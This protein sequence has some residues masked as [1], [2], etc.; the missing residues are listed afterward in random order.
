MK[1]KR[2]QRPLELKAVNEDGTFEGYGSVFGTIDSYREVVMPGAFAQTLAEHAEKGSMPALLWQHRSDSPIGVWT[3]MEEDDH[4][5]KMSGSLALGTQQGRE[6]HE[7]LK[8]GAV[9]GLSIGFTLYEGGEQ[10]NTEN[11]VVE[12][13]AINLW[14]TSIVTF[15]ANADAQITEVRAA[16]DA[17]TYPTEREFEKHLRDVGFSK[18]DALAIVSGGYQQLRRDSVPVEADVAAALML[19]KNIANMKP[20]TTS[21]EGQ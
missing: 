11:S 13:T 10:Y 18:S 21:Q 2:L 15:P 17:G 5:L 6:A 19:Q 20:T 4:G 14:E 16:L 1:I 3:A 12:L 7:L 8:M 9:K